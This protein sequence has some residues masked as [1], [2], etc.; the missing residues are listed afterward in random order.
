MKTL[1]IGLLAISLSC[2]LHA[3]SSAFDRIMEATAHMED[4]QTL[5]LSG[6]WLSAMAEDKNLNSHLESLRLLS[7]DKNDWREM[8]DLNWLLNRE[9]YELMAQTRTGDNESQILIKES[10]AGITDLFIW[11]TGDENV[12]LI[13]VKGLLK[14]DEVD[15]MNFDLD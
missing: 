9:G 13:H 14:A 2:C 12:S 10:S 4:R 5:N 3:Q 15:E 8:P 6:N 1:I 11:S 7:I